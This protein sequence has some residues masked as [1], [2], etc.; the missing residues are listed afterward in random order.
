MLYTENMAEL[1]TTELLAPAGDGQSFNAALG[2]GADAIYLGLADFNARKK[3]ENFDGDSLNE[4]IRRAHFYGVKIYVTV[5]TLVKDEEFPRFIETAG[6]AVK[7]G[8]DAFIVQDLGAAACLKAA[9]KGITLHASTQLGVHNLEGARM[10][11]KAGFSRVVLSR[12]TKIE[13]IKRIRQGTSLEIEYFV[14]GALCVA[15]SGNCYLSALEFG[16]SGN[17]GLCRQLCRLPYS[18]KCASMEKSGYLLSAKDL[19]L[20]DS[21]SELIEA[22][23]SSFKIE[24]RLR[25]PEYVGQ[26]TLIY[27]RLLDEIKRGRSAKLSAADMENLKIAYCRGNDYLSRAYLDNGTP[28]V[29]ESGFNNHTGIEIGT[30]KSVE[31]FKQGLYKVKLSSNRT[32]EAGDGLKFYEEI[33]TAGRNRG[34][35][36]LR[37]AASAGAGDVKPCGKGEYVFVTKAPL[38]E[39]Y[40]ARLISSK[41]QEKELAEIKRFVDIKLRL[42][43]LAGEP[44]E[45][46]AESLK[47]GE[48]IT[49]S[50]DI[51]EKARTA[52][53]SEDELKAQV[54]KTADSGFRAI[55]CEIE[56]DGVFALKST[57]NALRRRTLD[58]LREEIIAK[59]TPATVVVNENVIDEI[60]RRNAGLNAN[61]SNIKCRFVHSDELKSAKAEMEKD[62]LIVLC[63]EEYSEKEIARMLSVLG[64]DEESAALRLPVI[65]NGKDIEKLNALLDKFKGIKTLVSENLF[66]LEFAKRGYKVIAGAGHNIINDYAAREILRLGAS[67]F[68]WS[69]ESERRSGISGD[70]IGKMT[71]AHC[72]FKTLGSD[73]AHCRYSADMKLFRDGAEYKVRRARI[74]N[75][76]FELY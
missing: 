27:R 26:T 73:C 24:G 32:I 58:A 45:L 70:E 49:L 5:N 72:P 31:P 37:E 21:L 17:R 44:L 4:L 76:Y 3:A 6:K 66:G 39:G 35:R 28:S 34:G 62:G 42:K 75:C 74:C 22:G 65:A 46:E 14:Q 18:A 30:V 36:E 50:S 54:G 9:F 59:N 20:A 12:E 61:F 51:C 43:A 23:V 60:N 69:L 47:G 29:I 55:E 1:F 64:L 71:F 11:E 2:C 41:R 40:I 57:L 67:G 15:F 56:T 33:K 19:C 68:L 63:P 16:A 25:R 53:M 10:L 8:A 52:P 38:K 13:D 48:R 7:A